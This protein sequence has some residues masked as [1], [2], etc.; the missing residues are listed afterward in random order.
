MN[1]FENYLTK[2]N[3]IITENRDFLD[4]KNFKN[5]K[6]VNLEV[7]PEKFNYD[8][9]TNVS[10]V[11]SKEN[12]KDPNTL[13]NEIKKL[14]LKKINHFEKIEI[15]S[16]GFLN[17]KLSKEGLAFNINEI[18]KNKKNYG[19]KRSN[20]TFNVEFVSA[21][22]TGPMHVGHCRGA[23]FGDVLSNLLLFN[24]NKVVKEYYINDYGN[25]IKNFVESVFLRLREIKYK[26]KFIINENLY[27]GNYIKDIAKNIIENNKKIKVDSFEDSFDEIKKLSLKE[28]MH[29]IT[30]DLKKLGI[31]HDNFFSESDLIKK[32]LVNKTVKQLK[33]MNFVDEGFLDPPKGEPIKNWKKVKRLIF[34][35][36]E[37]GDDTDRAL[38]KNDGSWTYFANDVAYHSD[39][40]NRKFDNLI[41]IL[42]ADHTGYIKRI[43]A[44]VSALS[45]KRVNFIAKFVN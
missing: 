32:D 37:F 41:N 18:F 8:L 14:I 17:I 5:L 19:S 4:L 2:I 24:G 22:P 26:E 44:A 39:K 29:L 3:S 7:P 25:Q 36:T 27:P 20:Q 23:I 9:S 43:S 40:I 21:N 15:A 31:K 30:E 34:K 38:Q 6:S 33:D 12:Q 16:P 13:A 28:S 42:G 11:L 10:L 1:I 35:S 45:N